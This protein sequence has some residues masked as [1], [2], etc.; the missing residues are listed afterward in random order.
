M[1]GLVDKSKRGIYELSQT[2]SELLKVPNQVDVY[3][4]K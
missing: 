4:P 2:G 3:I 1:S